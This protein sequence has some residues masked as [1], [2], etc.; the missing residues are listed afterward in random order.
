MV[1]PGKA[2]AH[3]PLLPILHVC[4]EGDSCIYSTSGDTFVFTLLKEDKERAIQS[5]KVNIADSVLWFFAESTFP[6]CIAIGEC[7][8]PNQNPF[9]IFWNNSNNNNRGAQ[10]PV[11]KISSFG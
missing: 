3:L 6:L 4:L 8:L 10:L 9:C 5:C 11:Q 7:R 1:C 2:Q